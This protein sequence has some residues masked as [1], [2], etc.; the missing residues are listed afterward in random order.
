MAIIYR[1][2]VLVITI[3]FILI[4]PAC[5]EHVYIFE[6]LEGP[7]AQTPLMAPIA[8]GPEQFDKG[9]T[10]RLA[11]L[12]TEEDSHWLALARGLKTIGI[13]FRMT[14][15]IEDAL[16]HDIVMVYP[17]ITGVNLSIS[18]LESLRSYVKDGGTLVGTNVLGRSL[19]D[20][21]G[22]EAISESKSRYLL[23]F[24]NGAAETR[25]FQEKGLSK[26]KIGSAEDS[27]ANPGTNSYIG[28]AVK[29][30]ALYENGEAAIISNN[31]GA[32]KTYAL[33][34]D[35]GQLLAKGYN[36]RQ[37]DIRKDYANKYQPTLDA[38]L[39]FMEAIYK[40]QDA[41]KVT[42]GTVPEGKSLSFILSH[43][44]DFS[45]SLRNAIPYAE[46]QNK[47]NISGTYFI[48]TKYIRDYN[49]AIFFGAEA[50]PLVKK[51]EALG[52]EIGSHTVAHSNAMWEFDV[53]DGTESYPDYRPFVQ[54]KTRTR[55]A[56]LMGETR[57]SKFLL[58]NFLSRQQ[59]ESFRPGF[60]SN[61]DQM[62]E[63]LASTGYKYSSSTTANVSLTHLPFQLSYGR[64]FS[65]LTPI[66]E[67]PITVEDELDGPMI[68]RLEESV[69]LAR[70]I[71]KIGGLYVVLIHT[72]D[73][74]SRLDFQKAIVE[75][76][77]PYAWI[78]SM[79]NFGDWWAARNE[80]SVDVKDRGLGTYEILLNAKTP[81]KGLTIELN[82]VFQIM[83]SSMPLKN[84]QAQ[85]KVILLRQLSG[86]QTLIIRQ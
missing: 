15:D 73:V 45:K 43:D 26:I 84:I 30:L 70:R 63:V 50:G 55:G 44:I 56:T 14:H 36:R 28:L 8:L 34:L 1:N 24:Q 54:T 20:M 61:P 83:E 78:G 35:L 17:Q 69:D 19:A 60:L 72:D 16:R 9:E 27:A 51:L 81:I 82:N 74:D 11:I 46:H 80:V 4:L 66:F 3:F 67:F 71:A 49:D 86:Q 6:G 31:Y 53:G 18:E 79:R 47:E 41:P 57:I 22:F 37:V 59:V 58:D 76:V 23:Q 77:K 64:E 7:E 85:G 52:A 2:A 40:A 12:I 10:S 48:Q 13:P 39:M 5:S 25:G 38:M 75:E 29:P 68:E 62:P 21:F 65:A 32:G 33:G 42:L